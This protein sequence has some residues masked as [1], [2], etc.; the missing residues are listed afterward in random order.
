MDFRFTDRKRAG[1][2]FAISLMMVAFTTLVS[3]FFKSLDFQD[4]TL[5]ITYLLGVMGVAALTRGKFFGILASFLSVLSF[6]FFFTQPIFTFYINHPDY[7]VT[8]IVMF[9]AS[10]LISSLTTRLTHQTEL[11]NLR[12]ERLR[13]LDEINRLFIHSV[14]IQDTLGKV[15]DLSASYFKGEVKIVVLTQGGP[16][17]F[18]SVVPFETDDFE[19][20]IITHPLTTESEM[21]GSFS[22][23][24]HH[25]LTEE[26]AQF[27]LNVA[28]QISAAL[29]KEALL[30]T[31]TQAQIEIREQKL[32]N[33]LLGAISHDLRTPLATIIGSTDTIIENY[34]QLNE[35]IKKE[36][37]TNIRD[38]AEW[39]IESVE[40]ILS[41]TRVEDGKL[42]LNKQME[43]VEDL[44]GD[45]VS[46]VVSTAKQKFVLDVPDELLMVPMDGALME[47]VLLNLLNNA[48]KYSPLDSEITLRAY[49]KGKTAVF[50]VSDHGLGIPKEQHEKIFER[51]YSGDVG[52]LT[53]RKGLGLGLSICKAIVEAH[54]GSISAHDNHP[55][56][57]L[58]RVV[59]PLEG[60]LSDE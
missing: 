44:F 27:T 51:F 60:G 37:L 48:V 34:D 5:T 25:P 59:L 33:S 32:R 17:L 53:K 24:T 21:S 15:A 14:S 43:S 2:D 50:E 3:L 36:L 1:R 19:P 55:Q 38:D 29:E 10:V 42:K 57:S 18:K 6:N 11:S 58:F 23:K 54:N 9:V 45:L 31:Q 22:L 52:Y 13:L 12:Q 4:A 46:H 30:R 28:N 16:L 41:F 7:L 47:K 56:G 20:T 39:L 49:R 8:F 40:N 35:P 26:T